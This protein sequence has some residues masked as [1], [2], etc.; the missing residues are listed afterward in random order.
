MTSI[1]DQDITYLQAPLSKNAVSAFQIT[2]KHTS[3]YLERLLKK[4]ADDQFSSITKGSICYVKHTC[5][6]LQLFTQ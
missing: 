4:L 6:Y 2:Y 3:F 1:L 5:M